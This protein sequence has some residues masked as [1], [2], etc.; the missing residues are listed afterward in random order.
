MVLK[1]FGFSTNIQWRYRAPQSFATRKSWRP[2]KWGKKK[3]S[4]RSNAIF[5]SKQKKDNQFQTLIWCMQVEDNTI[6]WNKIW[7]IKMVTRAKSLMRWLSSM[8]L[9]HKNEI[10]NNNNK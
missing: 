4:K 6:Q 5:F 9:H 8:G 7:V 1:W 2:N 3:S 10:N